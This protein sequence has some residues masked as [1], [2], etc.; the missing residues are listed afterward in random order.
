MENEQI[1]WNKSKQ[2]N[3]KKTRDTKM[4]DKKV[5]RDVRLV[6]RL[7]AESAQIQRSVSY[8][9]RNATKN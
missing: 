7:Q 4:L 5:V 3:S 1:D 2:K 8:N 9:A 6:G